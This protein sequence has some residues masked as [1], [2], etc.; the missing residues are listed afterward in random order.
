MK[1]SLDELLAME[2]NEMLEAMKATYEKQKLSRIQNYIARGLEIFIFILFIFSGAGIIYTII[3]VLG[4]LYALYR[5]FK[6]HGNDL[7]TYKEFDLVVEGMGNLKKYRNGEITVD[8]P[9]KKIKKMETLIEKHLPHLL[10]QTGTD[11]LCK[12]GAFIPI[13]NIR[14]DEMTP[15]TDLKGSLNIIK[16]GTLMSAG[17]EDFSNEKLKLVEVESEE[18][19]E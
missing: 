6:P 4:L 1:K 5:L 12:I 17:L 11:K 19:V 16:V 8:I 14:M 7:D 3:A 10:E 18:T 2:S 13:I 9:E 15:Y